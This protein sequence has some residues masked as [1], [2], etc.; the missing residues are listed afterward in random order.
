MTGYLMLANGALF[1]GE[2]FGYIEDP[3]VAEVVFNTG[4]VG[5]QEVM[6]DPS[7][8]GQIVVMTYPLIG[9]YGAQVEDNEAQFSYIKGLVVKEACSHHFT[10][11]STSNRKT[12]EEYMHDMKVM[13]IKGIDTRYLTRMLREKGTMKGILIPNKENLEKE[14]LLEKYQEL[15][16]NTELLQDAVEQVTTKQKYVLPGK[17]KKVVVLD[18]GVKKSILTRLQS[19]GLEVVVVPSYT[20]AD[21]ILALNPAGLFLSNGPGDPK[22]V[23]GT[24]TTV[25]QLLRKLPIFG[26]CLGH[27]ILALA[28]GGDTYKLKFGHRGVNHPVKDLFQNKVYITSQNHSYAVRQDSLPQEVKITHV[29]LN[30]DTIEGLAHEE[31]PVMS[32]QYHPEAAPGPEE[33]AYLFQRFLEML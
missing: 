1:K 33:S 21:D 24:I 32:V 11:E 20:K 15:L 7:Y 2:M 14:D 12:L 23:E 8:Y 22:D 19:L 4:M 17:G 27:Q 31:L 13:G 16:N 18:L 25:K 9:N 10:G 6:T 5:Y 30:D 28:L 26:I 3:K 29:N